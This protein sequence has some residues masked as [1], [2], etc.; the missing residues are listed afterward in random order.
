MIFYQRSG[1]GHPY[2]VPHLKGKSSS[3]I[4]TIKYVILVFF[5]DVPCE[6]EE[7]PST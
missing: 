5:V 1:K 4:L 3:I 6:V 2:L 7:V